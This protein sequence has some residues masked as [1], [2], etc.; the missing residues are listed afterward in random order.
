MR[1]RSTR[2]LRL[3]CELRP[4]DGGDGFEAVCLDLD[5]GAW[6]STA[7]GARTRRGGSELLRIRVGPYRVLFRVDDGE[8]EVL[9]TRIAHRREFYR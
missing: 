9:V 8:R 6:A 7:E 1:H 5:E 3:R 2:A 4:I